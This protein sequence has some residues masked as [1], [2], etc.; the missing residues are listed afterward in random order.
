MI[1]NEISTGG[2]QAGGCVLVGTLWLTETPYGIGNTFYNVAKARR[3]K[4]EKVV[5]KGVRTVI[6]RR[7]HGARV[8]LYVDTLNG[9]WN[10]H[11]LVTHDKAV[12]IV[13]AYLDVLEQ[14]MD[15]I[16]C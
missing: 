5:I 15:R 2:I 11:D 4:L 1:Y 9:L 3:G 16:K 6:S 13:E 12:A 7:T 10:E 8:T 14:D